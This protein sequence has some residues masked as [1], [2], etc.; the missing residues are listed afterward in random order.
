[1]LKKIIFKLGANPKRSLRLFII[2]LIGFWPSAILVWFSANW[3]VL[4][5]YLSIALLAPFF[6]CAIYGYLGLFSNRF[7]QVIQNG[8]KFK[9]LH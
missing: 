5:F 8:D 2:G 3:G 6:F 1:M 9:S 4:W 7:A